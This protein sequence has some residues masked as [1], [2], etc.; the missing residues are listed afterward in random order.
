MSTTNML[1][2]NWLVGTV[3]VSIFAFASIGTALRTATSEQALDD[4][5]RVAFKNEVAV[6]DL[7][8]R[9]DGI[10]PGTRAK[11]QLVASDREPRLEAL[12]ALD[13]GDRI[14]VVGPSGERLTL[15]VELTRLLHT[16]IVTPKSAGTRMQLVTLTV[17]DRP[18]LAPV[19]LLVEAKMPERLP[20]SGTDRPL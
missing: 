17:V 15:E 19:H 4:A 11:F 5:Y 9:S 10:G 2:T 8:G 7:G 6:A 14:T 20:G 13:A 18:D 12:G 3:V 16:A 1:R